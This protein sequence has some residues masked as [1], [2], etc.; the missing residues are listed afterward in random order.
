[1][2][3]FYKEP[4]TL[5]VFFQALKFST[6]TAFIGNA[7]TIFKLRRL[8]KPNDV[9]WYSIELWNSNLS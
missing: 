4:R 9:N 2:S 1:M 8:G 3:A 5:F 7:T 6:D